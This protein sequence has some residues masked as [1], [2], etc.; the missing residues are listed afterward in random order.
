M[1][2]LAFLLALSMLTTG[3]ASLQTATQKVRVVTEPEGAQVAVMEEG[4]RKELGASPVEYQ[5][6]YQAY[7]CS[8]L[9]WLLPVATAAV[10]GGAGFG[11]AYATT[12][13]NDK[14]D[15][16]WNNGALFAAIGLAVGIA[17]A[18]ECRMKDGEVP[19]HREVRLVVEAAK[20]GFAPASAPLQVPSKTEELKLVLPP[21]PAST[22]AAK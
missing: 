19:D 6:S 7:R 10:A 2:V 22:D 13:R 16:G 8:M 21:L 12:A 3:C 14:L 20:E 11:I 17:V 1:R 4:G 15:S 18:A 5:R 9:T